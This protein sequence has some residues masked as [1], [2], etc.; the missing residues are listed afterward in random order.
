MFDDALLL[1]IL[2]LHPNSS[3]YFNI[4][5]LVADSIFIRHPVRRSAAETEVLTTADWEL[6]IGYLF[7]LPITFCL[8]P[9]FLIPWSPDNLIPWSPDNLIP[10]C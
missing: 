3:F 9:S 5:P 8:P 6:D 10:C 1:A 7:V 4:Y 2:F